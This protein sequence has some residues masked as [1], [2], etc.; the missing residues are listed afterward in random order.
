MQ[1]ECK[2]CD[3]EIEA[4][5]IDDHEQKCVWIISY[6]FNVT[7]CIHICYVLV[8]SVHNSCDWKPKRCQ[9]CNMVII[10]RDLQRHETSCKTNLKSCP[11]CSENV[12]SC[13]LVTTCNG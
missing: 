5:K 6:A 7:I 4:S 8:C 1:V 12:R 9:H 11:H 13:Y 10:S 2:F 3:D